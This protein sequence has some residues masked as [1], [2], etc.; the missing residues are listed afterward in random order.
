M[1]V[2]VV[3]AH[4]DDET[5][6]V[7]GTIVKHIEKKD[8]V[9]ILIL[10]DGVGAR[11]ERKKTQEKRCINACKKLGVNDIDFLRFPDQKLD[12]VPILDVIKK[13]EFFVKELSPDFV[14]THY[15]NDIN[16]DH[17]ITFEATMVACRPHKTKIKKI[18]CYEIPS[19][20]EWSL[21]N[22]PRFKPNHFVDISKTFE[23]KLEA[24]KEYSKTI[25][26]EIK[27]YPHP[28]SFDVIDS[29]SKIRGSESNLMRAE[30]FVIV[31]SIDY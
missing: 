17:Q 31:R 25:E 15:G 6:G 26:S 27:K 16:K 23:K 30:S 13:I 7:G 5:L 28:R 19:S 21:Y 8:H 18:L 2:L 24:F 11:G 20:T 1:K 22:R 9:K 29:L 12:S 4:P 3:A 10:T 14:Y